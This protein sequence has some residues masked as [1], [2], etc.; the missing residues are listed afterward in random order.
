MSMAHLYLVLVKFAPVLI[1]IFLGHFIRKTH[2]LKPEV[3]EG[4]KTI[5]VKLSLPSLLFLTFAQATLEPRYVLIFAALFISSLLMF[6]L[7]R[8]FSKLIAPGNKYYPA[9]FSSFEVGMLGYALF[10]AFFGADNT[11]KLAIFDIGH[12]V[13]VFFILVTFLQRQNGTHLSPRHMLLSFV[14]NPVIVAILAGILCSV[15]GFTGFLQKL[16]F[17]AAIDS[18]LSLLG[19]VTSPLICIVIGYELHINIKNMIK[20][21]FTVL[22]RMVLMLVL[23]FLINK[24]ILIGILQLDHSFTL[25]L[26]TLSVLPPTFII[27]LYINPQAE[28]DKNEILNVISLHILATLLAFLILVSFKI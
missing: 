15:T 12:T 7:G 8:P 4:L 2:L 22:L 24:F 14:K 18:T 1:L 21:L 11:Y 20:P 6:F 3:I 16:E 25:A 26:F 13:F 17:T 9:L 10:T 5:I 28:N 19:S 27:P 23:A